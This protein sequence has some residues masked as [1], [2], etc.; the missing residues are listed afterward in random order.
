[1]L[2]HYFYLHGFNSNAEG[3]TAQ[4]LKKHYGEDIT[5]ISYDYINAN[6]AHRQI[7]AAVL[8]LRQTH[9]MIFIGTSLGGFWANYFA[10]VYRQKCI[11]VNP[12]LNPSVSLQKYLGENINFNTGGKRILTL[13]NCDCYANYEIPLDKT[14]VRTTLLGTKDELI[15][16]KETA[17]KLEG[18]YIILTN[19]GHRV[20]NLQGLIRAID[21]IAKL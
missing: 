8:P 17:V 4:E 3:R 9:E 21:A 14:I 6:E 1:M 12:S 11:L 7:E 20:E 16:Y 2:R 5:A 10:Q 19:E 13:E 15:S 18:T